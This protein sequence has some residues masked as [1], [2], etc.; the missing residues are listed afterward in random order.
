[1]ARSLFGSSD[2]SLSD[3]NMQ[4]SSTVLFPSPFQPVIQPG[5]QDYSSLPTTSSLPRR[6][7]PHEV[8]VIDITASPKGTDESRV[9]MRLLKQ[10]LLECYHQRQLE[11]EGTN[12]WYFQMKQVLQ[13]YEKECKD[14]IQWNYCITEHHLQNVYTQ[15]YFATKDS[16]ID[17]CQEWTDKQLEEANEMQM[18]FIGTVSKR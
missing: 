4:P 5:T 3:Q 1:M 9:Q 7:S 16:L 6:R 2:K 15:E 8:P 18:Q 11:Q 17:E 12:Q 10:A 14:S 13:D